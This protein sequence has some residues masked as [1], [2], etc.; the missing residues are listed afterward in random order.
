MYEAQTGFD[1]KALIE[2]FKHNMNP[3]L[4]RVHLQLRKHSK[5]SSQ[6]AD[7]HHRSRMTAKG[8]A[9]VQRGRL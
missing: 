1:K 2:A 7:Y 9:A 5:N 6:L 4:L 8:T 3:R